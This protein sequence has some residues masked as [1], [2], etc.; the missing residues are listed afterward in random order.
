[1]RKKSE[2]GMPP[3]V[4]RAD[5]EHNVYLTVDEINRNADDEAFVQNRLWALGSSLSS[6][7]G[8][9][10]NRINLP[11]IDERIR[12]ISNMLDWVKYLPEDFVKKVSANVNK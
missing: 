12:S 5:M 3:P 8:L 10:N 9:P 2:Y 4:C 6:L 1:M 7:R 11:T